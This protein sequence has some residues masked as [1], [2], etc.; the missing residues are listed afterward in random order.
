MIFH[1]CFF[2]SGLQQ[3]SGGKQAA[4]NNFFERT[5]DEL[6]FVFG[7]STKPDNYGEDQDEV[8]DC[9][10]ELHQDCLEEIGFFS[11][12]RKNNI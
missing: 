1:A 2:Y 3:V 9:C 12:C 10:V 4:F 11:C 8:D 5:I 6:W 7:L